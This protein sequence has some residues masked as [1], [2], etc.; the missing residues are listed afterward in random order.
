[1]Y[2]NI[3]ADIDK[4]LE[5]L[6]IALKSEKAESRSHAAATLQALSK[7]AASAVPAL[8][9]ALWMGIK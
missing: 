5:K 1:V 6:L 3:V 4:Q 7:R 9:I 2:T 8:M